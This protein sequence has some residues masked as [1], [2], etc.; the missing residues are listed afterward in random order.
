VSW[1]VVFHLIA[2][3]LIMTG[4]VGTVVPGLPGVPLVYG[5]MVLWAAVES[6]TVVG[7]GALALL[8]GLALLSVGV[9]YLVTLWGVKRV[10]ASPWAMVGGFAG[11]F[12]GIAAGPVGILIGPL[13]GAAA[14]ELLARRDL[15]QA[16]RA[17]IAAWLGFLLGTVAKV[18]LVVLM[19]A[20][21]GIAM[22]GKD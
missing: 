21:F 16:G 11:A 13:V 12:A 14:G 3:L 6:F 15:R 19:L 2:L 5:G 22:L 10:G 7:F 8:G 9:E 18:V 4:V 1:E 17:G 20:V